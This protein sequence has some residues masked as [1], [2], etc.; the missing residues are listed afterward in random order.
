M[1]FQKDVGTCCLCMPLGL[2]THLIACWTFCYSFVCMLALISGDVRLLNGGYNPTTC[3][4][5]AGVGSLGVIF[6]LFGILGVYNKNVRFLRYFNYFQY[7]EIV[8]SV[9]V[10]VGDYLQLD[11]CEKW[12]YDVES[13]VYFNAPM[14][15][16]SKKNLCLWGR[17]AFVLGWVLHFLVDLYYTWVTHVYCERIAENPAYLIAFDRDSAQRGILPYN[18]QIG[19]TTNLLITNASKTDV[20][21][22]RDKNTVD[23]VERGSLLLAGVYPKKAKAG[24]ISFSYDQQMSQHQQYNV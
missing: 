1:G 5:S 24:S 17:H 12:I 11:K 8:A 20:E 10:F 3:W 6:G 22:I 16:L 9:L 2:G 19:E 18:P 21:G 13:Q 4:M 7:F 15:S 23:L 14:E